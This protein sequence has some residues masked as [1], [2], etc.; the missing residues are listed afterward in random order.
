MAYGKIVA[1][2][3]E[4]SSEGTVDTQYVVNGVPKSWLK[5]NQ[6]TPGIDN[7]LNVS[8]VT[9]NATAQYTINFTSNWANINYTN[10]TGGSYNGSD[11]TGGS[12]FGARHQT[13]TTSA[14][15]M[16]ASYGH[17]GSALDWISNETS[18]N[19]DLA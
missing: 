9:D 14:V 18:H 13:P 1:D 17:N 4:H 2:E 5:Y 19:G 10:T 7:S 15:V 12:S 11:A 6:V 3:I 16:I 8:T